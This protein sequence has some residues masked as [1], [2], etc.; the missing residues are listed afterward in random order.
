[1]AKICRIVLILFALSAWSDFP[2]A[3]SP[4]EGL[5]DLPATPSNRDSRAEQ[6]TSQCSLLRYLSARKKTPP[7]PLH[8]HGGL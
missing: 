5:A 2:G 3:C 8:W 6:L 4:K 1:M 7:E